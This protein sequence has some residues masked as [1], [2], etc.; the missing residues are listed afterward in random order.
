MLSTTRKNDG[1]NIPDT[2]SKL[3]GNDLIDSNMPM[4]ATAGINKLEKTALDRGRS[5]RISLTH[6]LDLQH[7]QTIIM[8]YLHAKVQG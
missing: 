8:T 4:H 7:L 6:D 2:Y 5:D 1:H 3:Y